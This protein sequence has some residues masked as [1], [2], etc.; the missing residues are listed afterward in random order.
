M[1]PTS[2]NTRHS[3]PTASCA[4]PKSSAA[5]TSSPAPIAASAAGSTPTSPGPNC[6]PSPKAPASRRRASGLNA[7]GGHRDRRRGASSRAIARLLSALVG[8]VPPQTLEAIL[9]ATPSLTRDLTPETRI[10][11][12]LRG[13]ALARLVGASLFPHHQVIGIAA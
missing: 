12:I 5:R 2:S 3:S 8:P 11:F 13:V 7:C 6:A 4:T 10:L 1:P 9:A